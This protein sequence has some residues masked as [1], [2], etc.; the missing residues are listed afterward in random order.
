MGVC[1]SGSGG[2]K[3]QQCQQLLT[4]PPSLRAPTKK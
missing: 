1:M 4:G 2:F 3:S